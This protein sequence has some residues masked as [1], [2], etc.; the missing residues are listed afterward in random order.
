LPT[1][2]NNVADIKGQ[3]RESP[4]TCTT[5]PTRNGLATVANYSVLPPNFE[6]CSRHQHRLKL[7]A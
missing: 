6:A 4:P 3:C 7:A 1:D 2:P 5:M